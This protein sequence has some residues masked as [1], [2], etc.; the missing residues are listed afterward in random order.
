M[1]IGYLYFPGSTFRMEPEENL[2]ALEQAC[3]HS[4]TQPF[5]NRSDVIRHCNTLCIK[6]C[7]LQSPPSIHA[8]A[9]FV[10]WINHLY[11]KGMALLLDGTWSKHPIEW[12]AAVWPRQSIHATVEMPVRLAWTLLESVILQKWKGRL[13][14]QCFEKTKAKK[15]KFIIVTLGIIQPHVPPR[16]I[17]GIWRWMS[18]VGN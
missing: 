10:K 4:F 13:G 18:D 1:V 15:D 3:I 14:A 11:S 7:N 2:P 5:N 9:V 12:R 8:F 17:L 16:S 6:L